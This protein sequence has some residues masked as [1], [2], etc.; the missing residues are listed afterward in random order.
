[1]PSTGVTVDSQPTV[2]RR[3]SE[4]ESETSQ[5]WFA[6]GGKSP[7]KLLVERSKQERPR[8]TP[9][10]DQGTT[11]HQ[12][13]PKQITV[14]RR[15]VLLP[16]HSTHRRRHCRPC[17]P[18]GLPDLRRGRRPDERRSGCHTAAMPRQSFMSAHVC[19][20]SS[21]LVPMPGADTGLGSF[22]P[23]QIERKGA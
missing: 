22:S 19:R 4:S 21:R 12:H 23:G 13:W 8:P 16:E 18:D 17:S 7:R 10:H 20:K 3:T 1:M 9:C 2:L 14:A 6:T 15:R 11:A 5:M